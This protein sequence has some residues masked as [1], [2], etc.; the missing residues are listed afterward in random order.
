MIGVNGNSKKFQ[1]TAPTGGEKIWVE[2][3]HSFLEEEFIIFF[4]RTIFPNK[5]KEVWVVNS[6]SISL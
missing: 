6:R 4:F 5:E 2:D 1:I 3:F